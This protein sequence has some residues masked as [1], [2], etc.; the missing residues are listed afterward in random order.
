M[1][2]GSGRWAL[3]GTRSA[4]KHTRSPPLSTRTDWVIGHVPR[5]GQATD[6]RERLRLAVRGVNGTARS[7]AGGSS[8][9]C[10]RCVSGELKLSP[11]D[12]IPGVWEAQVTRPTDHGMYCPR[13]I[14]VQVCV[15]HPADVGRP[16][17]ELCKRIFQPLRPSLPSFAT[18]VDVLE[19]VV[20]LVAESRIPP[21]R[22]P[23]RAST[24]RQRSARESGCARRPGCALPQGLWHDAEHGA[25]VEALH[26]S[27]EGVA[28]EAADFEGPV[29]HSSAALGIFLCRGRSCR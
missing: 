17:A 25:A 27:F 22:A 7:W 8:P 23:R 26:S 9:R 3:V 28:G 16:V 13:V 1:I 15:D 21:G 29:A 11:L 24:R 18:P 10:A 2:Q 6:T 19:L 12:H 14:E 4:R 20:F 5:R